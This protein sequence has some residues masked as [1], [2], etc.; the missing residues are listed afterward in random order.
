[1]I[2]SLARGL[3]GLRTAEAR[4]GQLAEELGETRRALRIERSSGPSQPLIGGLL[5]LGLGLIAAIIVLASRLRAARIDVEL[6]ALTHA[7]SIDRKR[8][9]VH[10]P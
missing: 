9:A 8:A 1:L 4:V 7:E 3:G 2:G 5:A 6:Q 10:R